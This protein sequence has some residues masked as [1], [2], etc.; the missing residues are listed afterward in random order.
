M[1]HA[2]AAVEPRALTTHHTHLHV[3]WTAALG[4]GGGGGVIP[5]VQFPVRCSIR[6][7]VFPCLA[8]DILD[9][10]FLANVQKVPYV[11]YVSLC[12]MYSRAARECDEGESYST[13]PAVSCLSKVRHSYC[14]LWLLLWPL[15]AGFR[16]GS[17]GRWVL[18][19]PVVHM[20]VCAVEMDPDLLM[21]LN[22][23]FLFFYLIL[24]LIVAFQPCRS[25]S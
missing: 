20:E 16:R 6:T 22:I 5:P 14:E 21:T 10:R 15:A 11:L 8:D 18:S 19:D 23:L 13:V 25:S 12:M 2:A 7:G 3:F 4:G 24:T 1:I 17:S 9:I